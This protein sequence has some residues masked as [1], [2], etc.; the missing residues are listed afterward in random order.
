MKHNLTWLSLTLIVLL[1]TP[2]S[3][4][5]ETPVPTQAFI[6]APIHSQRLQ[7]PSQSNLPNTIPETTPTP[8]PTPEAT[9]SIPDD[10]ILPPDQVAVKYLIQKGYYRDLTEQKFLPEEPITRGAFITLLY[11]ASGM[12]TP[13]VSEF[14]YFKDVPTTYWAYIPIEAFRMR[15]FLT[16]PNSGYFKPNEPI[17][18]AEAAEYLSKTFPKKWLELQPHE[19]ENTLGAYVAPSDSALSESQKLEIAKAVYA[20]FLSPLYQPNPLQGQ[21]RYTLGLRLPLTRIDAARMVYRKALVQ[22]EE[23]TEQNIDKSPQIPAGISL[24]ITPTSAL[25]SEQ[26]AVGNVFYTSLVQTTEIPSLN[27]VL[28][29]GSRFHAEVTQLSADHLQAQ[30]VLNRVNIPSG[31]IFDINAPLTLIFQPVKKTEPDYIVPGEKFT[32]ITQSIQIP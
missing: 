30:V 19:V 21:G 16:I 32:V 11:R 20:G 2:I 6:V 18:R 13:F 15:N 10:I 8:S 23:I 28:P 27:L 4:W 3:S 9:T 26:I 29:Q 5:A 25:S 7:T 17:T 31:E 24:V 22:A 12:L 1:A 14:P